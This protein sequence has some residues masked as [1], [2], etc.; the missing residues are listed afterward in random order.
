MV[1]A[2]YMLSLII[3]VQGDAMGLPTGSSLRRICAFYVEN[4]EEKKAAKGVS[5]SFLKEAVT[6]I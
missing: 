2:Y 3:V 4:Y 1:C 6:F 5:G